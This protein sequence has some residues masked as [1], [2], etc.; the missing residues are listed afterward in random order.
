MIWSINPAST[1]PKR[2]NF[3]CG[4][5]HSPSRSNSAP[6]DYKLGFYFHFNFIFYLILYC[7]FL[8]V[9]ISLPFVMFGNKHFVVAKT[10]QFIDAT[11]EKKKRKTY[12][13]WPKKN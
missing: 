7:F 13:D 2:I 4:K 1:K 6:A 10:T 3:I 11:K 5:F 12:I 9:V 8:D